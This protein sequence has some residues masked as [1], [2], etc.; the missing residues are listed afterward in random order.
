[1]AA[2]TS[3]EV[4]LAQ[5]EAEQDAQEGEDLELVASYLTQLSDEEIDRLSNLVQVRKA[6]SATEFTASN[7][8]D[9][10]LFLPQLDDYWY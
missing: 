5:T 10:E 8:G 3:D 2:S 7:Q 1:M 6:A 4:T 9:V